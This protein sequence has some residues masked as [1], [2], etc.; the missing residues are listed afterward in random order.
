[1]NIVVAWLL[2]PAVLTALSLGCGLLLE[3]VAAVRL[4]H[5][6]VLPAGFAVVVVAAQLAV[7]EPSTARLATPLV[8]VLAVIGFGL[9]LPV[10]PRELWPYAAAAATFAVYAA[11]IVLSGQATFAG[12]IKLDDTSTFLGMTDRVLDHGRSLAGLAPSTYE[13]SLAVNLTNGYPLGALLPLGIGS[14]LS[15]VDPAWTFQPCMAFSAAMLAIAL[16][17]LAAQVVA[18]RPL[19]ALAAFVASQAALLYAFSLWGGIKELAAA[20]FVA[21]VAALLPTALRTGATVR[22]VLPSAAAIAAALAVLSLGGAIWILPVVVPVLAVG[23]WRGRVPALARATALGAAAL[24]LAVPSLAVAGSFLRHDNTATFTNRHELGNLVRPLSFLQLFGIWP[25]GDFRLPSDSPDATHVLIGVVIVAAIAGLVLAW[26]RRGF[27]LIL[28]VATALVVGAAL[29]HRASPW[30]AAKAFA[31]ASPAFL[32]AALVGAFAFFERGRRVEGALAAAAIAGGVLWSNVLAYHDVWLAPRTQLAELETIGKRFHGLGP[33]LM[34]QYQP[35]GVRHFLR[36]LDPEGASELRRRQVP[37]RS[38]RLLG[39]AEFADADELQLA[40]VLVYRTLVLARSPLDSRPPSVY[41][42]VWRGRFYDVWE[43]PDPAPQIL[44]HVPLGT[45]A[46]AEAATPCSVVQHVASEAA[47]RG[48]RVAGVYRAPA[49]LVPLS[50]AAIPPGW[51]T[52]SGDPNIVYPTP[53]GTLRARVAVPVSGS[54]SV[55]VGGSFLRELAVSIDGKHVAT[56]HQRLNHDREYTPFGTTTLAA[57]VHEVALT[58]SPDTLR[59]GSGGQHF[60]VGPLVL[61]RATAELPVTYASPANAA[62]TFCG[63][64]LDWI[65]AVR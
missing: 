4:P 62:Q 5:G 63:R 48:G 41:S 25:N 40:A 33:S 6:L 42:L 47:A 29:A 9:A 15:G 2:F 34:T 27:G 38:G 44:D 54:Y 56:S 39:K 32:L 61:S 7:L 3:R 31:T 14:R 30:V 17:A 43:R 22:A 45:T 26:F 60:G 53:S 58:Y 8:V 59:P 64:S 49:V 18:S 16:Y 52:W 37:L 19:R 28:Y 12:Y 50:T 11:P 51:V 24:V 57:G 36:S 1:V 55:W 46:Q 65:E 20:P 10:R 13:V 35:Y 23:L 21:L